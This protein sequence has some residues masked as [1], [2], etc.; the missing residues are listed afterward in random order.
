MLLGT[1]VCGKTIA[2][3]FK[4]DS[5]VLAGFQPIATYPL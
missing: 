5:M 2:P 3:L 1:D 4:G